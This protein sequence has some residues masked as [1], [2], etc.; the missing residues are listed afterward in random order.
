MP[1]R[2]QARAALRYLLPMKVDDPELLSYQ[3][4]DLLRDYVGQHYT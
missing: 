4:D 2:L 3:R 1:E